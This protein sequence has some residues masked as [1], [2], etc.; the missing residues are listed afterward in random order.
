VAKQQFEQRNIGLD[1][2]RILPTL[3]WFNTSD[4]FLQAQCA[5]G[6]VGAVLV[7][8]GIAP[9]PSL[10]LL[11]LIYLS[12]TTVCRDFL[13]FQWDNLLL[14]TGLV[15]LFLA[16]WRWRPGLSRDLPPS[17]L[18]IW[19]LRWLLFRLMFASGYVKLLSRDPSWQHLTALT[20][21]YETEPLPTWIAWYVHQLPVMFHQIVVVIVFTVELGVPFLVFGPRRVRQLAFVILTGFQLCI[22]ATGNHAFLNLL[23]IVLNCVLLDDQ[24]LQKLV[25]AGWREWFAFNHAANAPSASQGL[26]GVG[27]AHHQARTW[28]RWVL[29]PVATVIMMVSTMQMIGMFRVRIPWPM[30]L[31]V[32]YD[33]LTPFRSIDSY[34]LFAVMT[35]VR[36]EIIVEGSMDGQKWAAYEFKH[37]PGNLQ[38]RPRFVAPFQPR[39]DW[40]MWFAALGSYRD[41]PWFI[42]FCIRLLQGS[43]PVLALLEKN[44][45]PQAP[46]RYIRAMV[47]NYDFTALATRRRTGAWW[48]RTFLGSY[49]PAF[50]LND[51]EQPPRAPAK[52]GNVV[53]VPS[54]KG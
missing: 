40:Q 30:P 54:P 15:A 22:I 18:V 29:V 3:C 4:G 45:F 35:R 41:N 13:S 32:G 5:A 11:W 31:L 46:P 16:P 25:P 53:A 9:A 7:V 38:R 37:K 50:S 48:E 19:L 23:S 14:E 27:S 42:N 6:V 24:T 8:F 10:F 34:G 2:Y 26:A 20:V 12:L 49:C 28:P 51:L 36:H 33:W 43:P 17:R 39:L 21:Y 1:G 47:Y 44:P 52:K